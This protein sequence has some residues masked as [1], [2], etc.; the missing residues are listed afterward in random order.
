MRFK[1][2]F[3]SLFLLLAGGALGYGFAVLAPDRLKTAHT[4]H[5]RVED[6]QATA[7]GPGERKVLYWYDPMYPGTKFDKPGKSPFMD[8]EL[9]P[10]YA[11]DDEGTGIRIDPGQTQ[12]LA[13]RTEKAQRG[14]LVFSHEIPANVEFNAY[15]L[16]KAQPRADGFV[17]KTYALAVGDTV[18][19]GQP[20]VDITVPAWAADQSE[21]LLLRSQK[22][23]PDI[24]RGVRERLRLSGMPEDLLKAVDATGRVQTRLTVHAPLGG[25]ITA[26]D[27]YPGMNVDKGM[28]LATIQGIDPVWVT[29]DVPEREIY[30]VSD[31]R[32]RVTI[33]AYPGRAFYAQSVTL[34]PKADQATRTVPL[35]LSLDNREGLLKPGL[36]ASIRLRSDGG[37]DL[38]IPT[39]SLIDL[40]DE[41]RV[42]VRA[43]D[44]SFVPRQVQVLRSARE[45]TAVLSGLDEGDEV[46]VSGIFLIDSE[47]NL[48]GALDRM[49]R[50]K[51]TA[52]APSAHDA[53]EHNAKEV[54]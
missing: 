33:P 42:I 48:R 32:M 30:L 47:A 1:T 7:Q 8:M 21:Y 49:R 26:I 28:T 25:V 53:H 54:E 38:L 34:L 24:I 35:R 50:A 45:K 44:G 19:A 2:F 52:A 4:A 18:T 46:V 6:G 29:A 36:T 9:V 16:A 40:G 51:E 41:Q 14:R 31:K 15:Q 13:V 37:E 17:E 43:A 27:A 3:L 23:A 11:E 10:R 5:E 20:L 12:N 22:A 39:Q